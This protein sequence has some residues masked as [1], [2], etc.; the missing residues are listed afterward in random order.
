MGIVTCAGLH[1]IDL[2]CTPLANEG[3]LFWFFSLFLQLKLRRFAFLVRIEAILDRV[4]S[5]VCPSSA[6]DET[7]VCLHLP[8]PRSTLL[9]FMEINEVSCS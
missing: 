7:E 9:M 2:V 3:L 1:E 4:G 6:V 8:V 5:F